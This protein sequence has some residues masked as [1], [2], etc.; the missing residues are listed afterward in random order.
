M[1]KDSSELFAIKKLLKSCGFSN[2]TLLNFINYSSQQ[3]VELQH[4]VELLEIVEHFQQEMFN[5]TKSKQ[6]IQDVHE[7][8]DQLRQYVCQW[9]IQ[10][11]YEE[12]Y[13]VHDVP[14]GV[15]CY[16]RNI[17]KFET[18]IIDILAER[19]QC[20]C[21]ETKLSCKEIIQEIKI[22]YKR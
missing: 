14:L 16:I 20:A 4:V 7:R 10:K 1:S 17:N 15:E 21:K 6:Y 2:S 5:N 9:L 11:H 22:K 12:F 8:M 18:E 19:V 3:K 13:I